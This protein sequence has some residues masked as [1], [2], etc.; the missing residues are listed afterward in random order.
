MKKKRRKERFHPQRRSYYIPEL[1]GTAKRV[2]RKEEMIF[3]SYFDA[4]WDDSNPPFP[5]LPTCRRL[6][7]QYGCA[8]ILDVKHSW[9]ESWYSRDWPID[10]KNRIEGPTLLVGGAGDPNFV[11]SA[12]LHEL[13]HHILVTQHRN[14]KAILDQEEEAW[15]IAQD[16]AREHRLPLVARARR[17]GLSSH[18]FFFQRHMNRGS[19]KNARKR[20]LPGS[21]TLAQSKQAALAPIPKEPKPLGKKGRRMTKKLLKR[22]AHKAERRRKEFE[23]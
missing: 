22:L 14:P 2:P 20:P 10:Y 9:D 8:L 12:L 16:L 6:A 1:D 5:W 3:P 7:E 13:G 15:K 11:C 23:V 21:W 4:N 18:R 17:L 19:R